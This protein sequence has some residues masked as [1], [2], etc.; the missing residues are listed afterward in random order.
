MLSEEAQIGRRVRVREAHRAPDRRGRDGTI[1]RAWGDP[2]YT[3]LDVLLDD[4]S[5]Q[6]FWRHELEELD[7]DGGR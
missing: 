5:R 6:L 4:V 1:T 7:G 3:A 2:N